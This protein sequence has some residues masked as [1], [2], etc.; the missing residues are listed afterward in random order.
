MKW[1]IVIVG[2]I[3][4]EMIRITV[5]KNERSSQKLK[6]ILVC[7]L[8]ILAGIL[9]PFFIDSLTLILIIEGMIVLLTISTIY[10]LNIKKEQA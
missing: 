1:L 7:L 8:A 3:L 6:Q 4:L 9:T 5:F 10:K 2:V